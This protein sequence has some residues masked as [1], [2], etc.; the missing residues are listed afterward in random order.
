MII[1]WIRNGLGQLIV[2]LNAVFKPKQLKRL[3]EIQ[4]QVDKVTEN[5]ALY[6]F[7][8]CPFCVK[9]RREITRL[10]L[11][12]KLHDAY[13]NKHHEQDLITGGGKRKVPCLR[14]E[15]ENETRWL[16]ESKD[17]IHHL[18]SQFAI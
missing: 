18:Q 4:A 1:K 7:H 5:L 2:I 14:I 11:R 9:V 8:R 13:N 17:I 6:E 12:I 3:P 15:T 10:N 16:Y